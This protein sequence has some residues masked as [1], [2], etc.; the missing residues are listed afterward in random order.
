MPLPGTDGLVHYDV[1]L[2][3]L[4]DELLDAELGELIELSLDAELELWLDEL[5]SD[6]LL[7]D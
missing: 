5:D 4:L 2:E 3:L 7:D 6:E 1:L